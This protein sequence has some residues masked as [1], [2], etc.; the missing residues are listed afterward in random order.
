MSILNYCCGCIPLRGG[1]LAIGVLTLIVFLLAL[2]IEGNTFYYTFTWT[3]EPVKGVNNAT[4]EPTIN[5]IPEDQYNEVF[6]RLLI[7]QSLLITHYVIGIVC[8]ALL[9][10]GVRKVGSRKSHS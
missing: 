2:L 3:E 9:I 5:G 10:Y 4:G 8:A 7:T 1:S 6:W